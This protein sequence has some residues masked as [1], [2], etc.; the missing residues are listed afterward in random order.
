[1][2]QVNGTVVAMG[3]L[4][5]QHVW[6]PGVMAGIRH[7]L[8]WQLG[9]GLEISVTGEAWASNGNNASILKYQR[10]LNGHQPEWAERK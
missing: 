5:A 1:M 8:S 9:G 3:E 7:L 10:A 2:N 4:P 6:S